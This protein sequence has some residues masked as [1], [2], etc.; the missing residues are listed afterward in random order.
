MIDKK[1]KI[2]FITLILLTL[3]LLVEGFFY[4]YSAKLS[5]F[6]FD[7]LRF[8]E[9]CA[10]ELTH[11]RYN[12]FDLKKNGFNPF[13]WSENGL[14][15]TIQVLFIFATLF[16]LVVILKYLRKLN[17][18]NF[19]FYFLIF[20]FI[21]ISY[22]FFEEIS[23]GQHFFNWN[24]SDFFLKHNNQKE[25]NLHNI[26]NLFDQLPRSLLAMWCSFSFIIFKVSNKTKLTSNFKTFILPSR[27]LVYISILI[28]LFLLP[29][30]IGKLF[31]ENID[32]SSTF[33]INISDIY[34]FFTFN[35]IRLSEYQELLFCF[36]LF[37]HSIFFKKNFIKK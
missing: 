27:K 28:I 13:I 8:S 12:I 21:C 24:S 11:K 29:D 15:E 33:Y 35:F 9:F 30:T 16:N 1:F 19:F 34:T 20:Y 6:C 37:Y 7:D 22:Y 36:Y 31:F 5:Y 23:W 10:G 25:T 17:I 18:N 2:I 26:S 32:Y 14:V 4:Y 3:F